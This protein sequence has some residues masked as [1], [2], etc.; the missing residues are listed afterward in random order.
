MAK[1]LLYVLLNNKNLN[2]VL[3]EESDNIA[4]MS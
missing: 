4:S 2:S 1:L 3:W